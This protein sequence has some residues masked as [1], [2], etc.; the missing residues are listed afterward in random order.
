LPVKASPMPPPLRAPK[1]N[2]GDGNAHARWR[3]ARALT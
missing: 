1:P 3:C 2:Q